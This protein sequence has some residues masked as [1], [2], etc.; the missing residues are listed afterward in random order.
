M[1]YRDFLS[2][3]HDRVRKLVQ[4]TEFAIK[5]AFPEDENI[6]FLASVLARVHD[7][8]EV[9]S[10]LGDIPT[11]KKRSSSPELKRFIHEVEKK[12]MLML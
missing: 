3:H 9:L 8:G 11:P 12:C 4:N 7:L 5:Y 6:A 1:Y 2:A 10:P